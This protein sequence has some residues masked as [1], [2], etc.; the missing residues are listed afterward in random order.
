MVFLAASQLL[1]KLLHTANISTAKG[2]GFTWVPFSPV[3][4]C[5]FDSQQM[6]VMSHC[7]L[8]VHQ[9]VFLILQF[10]P[11]I[12]TFSSRKKITPYY[13][14]KIHSVMTYTSLV[15]TFKQQTRKFFFIQKID[16]RARSIIMLAKEL[17]AYLTVR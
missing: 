2:T 11:A 3:L 5:P 16:T 17:G 1:Y 4:H 14:S 8:T 6:L 7:S 12:L 9:N 13:L 15:T 10:L